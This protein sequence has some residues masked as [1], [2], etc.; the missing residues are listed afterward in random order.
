MKALFKAIR[1]RDIEKVTSLIEKDPTLV[2]CKAKQPPKKHDGQSPLQVALKTGNHD[3]AGFL[4]EH[5]ADVNYMEEESVNEWRAPVIHDAIRAAVFSSRYSGIDGLQSTAE[6]FALALGCIQRIIEAGAEAGAVDSYGNNCM[7][8]MVMDANQL[9]IS[10]E[11][12]ELNEDLKQIFALLIQAGG[13][14]H[15]STESRKSVVEMFGHRPVGRVF[16]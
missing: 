6:E 10:D 4:I 16:K 11:T 13:D 1:K 5:G 2:N 12:T 15:Q 7:M 14:V 8:R 3:I 9:E